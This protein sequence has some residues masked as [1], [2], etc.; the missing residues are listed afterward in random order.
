MRFGLP[1]DS[2]HPLFGSRRARNFLHLARVLL[3]MGNCDRAAEFTV[4]AIEICP[5]HASTLHYHL[6]QMLAKTRM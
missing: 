4:A 5:P 3:A 2:V 6:K 1:P